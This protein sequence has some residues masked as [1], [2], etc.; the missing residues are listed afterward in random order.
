[1]KAERTSQC[2]IILEH[3]QT[4][5]KIT[6]IEAVTRFGCLRLGARI[7]DLKQAGHKIKT[8]RVIINNKQIAEYSLIN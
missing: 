3:L 7:H 5:K 2:R 1:M 8:S 4:G 6:S